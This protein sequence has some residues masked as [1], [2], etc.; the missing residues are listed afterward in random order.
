MQ[1]VA[2]AA[3]ALYYSRRRPS[4]GVTDMKSILVPTGGSDSDRPVFVYRDREEELIAIARR[5]KA[6]A[7]APGAAAAPEWR[8]GTLDRMAVVFKQPIRLARPSDVDPGG[9]PQPTSGMSPVT[10]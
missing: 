10:A 1:R 5:L 7:G 6:G 3:A 2:P 4:N 8:A 9:F